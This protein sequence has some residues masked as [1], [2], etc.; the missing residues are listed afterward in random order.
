V[1]ITT[2]KSLPYI[3]P[4]SFPEDLLTNPKYI[5]DF[6]RVVGEIIGYKIDKTETETGI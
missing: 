4:Q 6:D 5:E 2:I 3:E 1:S